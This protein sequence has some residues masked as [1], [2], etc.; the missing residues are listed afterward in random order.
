MTSNIKAVLSDLVAVYSTDGTT[1]FMSALHQHYDITPSALEF[2]RDRRRK[3]TK[4]G[5]PIEEVLEDCQ[6]QWA[7]RYDTEELKN[8]W[9]SQYEPIASMVD[10]YE[11]IRSTS[12]PL[13]VG[14]LT[15]N[16][17]G[18]KEHLD[19]RMET[20]F[21]FAGLD[22]CFDTVVLSYRSGARKPQAEIY[23]EAL[24]GLKVEA[25]DVVFVDDKQEN[26]E[27]AETLGI[28]TT[29]LF[30]NPSKLEA[31]LRNLGLVFPAKGVH[32]N[33]PV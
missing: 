6:R 28:M 26:L 15:N 20:R 23:Q 12:P 13:K 8:L 25:T 33:P 16:V 27:G 7:T 1:L 5:A 29:L 22:D 17:L 3:A 4:T 19:Q 14:L 10:L 18:I 11:R 24:A 21:G 2:F 30:V 9:L 31:D 32:V